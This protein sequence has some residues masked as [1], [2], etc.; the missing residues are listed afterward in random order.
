MLTSNP[1]VHVESH[2]SNPNAPRGFR[3]NLWKAVKS[4]PGTVFCHTHLRSRQTLVVSVEVTP[5]ENA[6]KYG[7]ELYP[8]LEKTRV[9]AS[10]SSLCEY[11]SRV[12]VVLSNSP[13]FGARVPANS[14]V[15]STRVLAFSRLETP[16]MVVVCPL[17]NVSSAAH[18]TNSAGNLH[19]IIKKSVQSIS[20]IN[21]EIPNTLCRTPDRYSAMGTQQQSSSSSSHGH[22]SNPTEGEGQTSP[23]SV[24]GTSTSNVRLGVAGA[25]Q[26]TSSSNSNS[27]S[28]ILPDLCRSFS[29]VPPDRRF[30]PPFCFAILWH[31]QLA[32][33]SFD[34]ILDLS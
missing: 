26:D 5:P 23:K 34:E 21:T 16:G 25:Q 9:L 3:D 29:D 6:G 7:I 28:L 24:G 19:R 2:D 15:M 20:H 1:N 4:V 8:F 17:N 33:T 18:R 13:V 22:G 31:A 11:S 27:S 14:R 12:R 10:T 32:N 30:H